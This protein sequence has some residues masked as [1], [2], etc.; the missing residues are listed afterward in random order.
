MRI[1]F[2]TRPDAKLDYWNAFE[3]V[4]TECRAF[5]V[6][7][8]D[9][10]SL[11]FSRQKHSLTFQRILPE[12]TSSGNTALM[13]KLPALCP[14]ARYRSSCSLSRKSGKTSLRT[15]RSIV[16]NTSVCGVAWLTKRGEGVSGGRRAE[17]MCVCMFVCV[18]LC[19]CMRACVRAF[20]SFSLPLS[21]SLSLY[22]TLSVSYL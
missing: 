19:A 15:S 12:C 2:G 9:F 13:Q 7:V 6:L 17:M 20:I 10:F 4:S 8:S 5:P 3:N 21:L 1:F 18:C 22:L 11:R 14:V 16:T